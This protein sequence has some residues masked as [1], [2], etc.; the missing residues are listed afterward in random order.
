MKKA[1]HT[2]VIFTLS[3]FITSCSQQERVKGSGNIVTEERKVADYHAIDLTGIG[4]L[5]IQQGDKVSLSIKTDDN[6]LQYIESDVRDG[7]LH[8]GLNREGKS[9]NL[10]P[11]DNIYYAAT[12]KN[13]DDLSVSGFSNVQ[14]IQKINSDQLDIVVN[15]AVALNLDIDVKKL[16]ISINGLGKVNL[17]GT[18]NS[19]KID[20]AG[21]GSYEGF[22]LVVKNAEVSIA[23]S[24]L[25]TLNVSDTLDVILA[26]AGKVDYKGNPKVTS[27]VSGIGK[28][29]KIGN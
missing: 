26:G 5:D 13:L 24:G 11:S 8:I 18:A 20:I 29:N 3:L 2:L 25:V 1:I 14:S 9:K 16:N 28:L 27:K 12:V 19:V 10:N 15:G 6:L 7:V 22:D 21:A 4:H 17:S 23:G